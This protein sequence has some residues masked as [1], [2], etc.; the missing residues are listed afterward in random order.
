LFYKL[1]V[2]FIQSILIFCGMKNSKFPFLLLF[3]FLLLNCSA[4]ES[5][6]HPWTRFRGTDGM[7]IDSNGSAPIDWDSSDF[8]WQTSLPGLGHSSPVVWERTIYVTSAD[9]AN[10]MGYVMAIDEQDGRILWQKE[11]DVADLTMHVD[12]NLA[13]SSPAV[14]ESQLYVIWY[15]KE[16]ATLTALTHDGEILWQSEFDG[17]EA[18]HGGGSSLVLTEKNVVFTREQ[19]EGSSFKSSWV[20]VDKG[21]GKIAWELERETCTRNS[22]S[23]PI[24]VKNDRQEAQL[25][26]TSEA[27]GFTGVDPE[28]GQVLWENKGLLTHR[29]VAS[30][31]YSNGL[32]VGCRKGEG[33]VVGVDLNTHKVADTALYT[34]PPNL[35]PYL[36]TP[37]VKGDL[38][39]IFMDNG[40]V[41][42]VRL[43]SGEILWKE[44]P[45][46]PLYGSPVWVDGKLYCI[47]K[48]GKVIVIQ[49]DSNYKLHGIHDLGEGSFSTPVMCESGMVFRTF[50]KLMLLG[51]DEDVSQKGIMP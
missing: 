23:T 4:Q 50:S 40:T 6:L 16:K 31:L 38:L 45:A 14:D 36:P 9:D 29:V 21:S 26:F 51:N 13:S 7:G 35:S 25:I 18:R 1:P 33:M 34:L 46:G 19:E 42:C 27:H 48:A 17:I 2:S 37:L 47:S 20:A 12:N 5:G 10:H 30:P 11:F 24:L 49:A 28:T 41:A 32:L 3:L 15:A 39:F 22:F 8:K 44:R 43:A